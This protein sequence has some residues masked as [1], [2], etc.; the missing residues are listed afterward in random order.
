VSEPEDTGPSITGRDRRIVASP[1][2]PVKSLTPASNGHRRTD[3]AGGER[4]GAA[5]SG[6]TTN[7][8]TRARGDSLALKFLP[9]DLTRDL[10]AKARS[11]QEAQAVSSLDRPNICTIHEIDETDEGQVFICMSYYEGET[12]KDKIERGPLTLKEALV[13]TAFIAR[14]L[15]RPTRMASFIET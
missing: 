14:G 12:L 7:S 1:K 6:Q 3:V 10:E 11:T 9:A 8:V 2:A 15:V 4:R 13:I 5:P